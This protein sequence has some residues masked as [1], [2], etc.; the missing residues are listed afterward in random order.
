MPIFKDLRLFSSAKNQLSVD[1]DQ[2]SAS[3]YTTTLMPVG[4][5]IAGKAGI[6][7]NTGF[8]V[9]PGMTNCLEEKLSMME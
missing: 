8:R 1:S 9:R 7:E 6:R 3:L 5:V 4:N 2:L